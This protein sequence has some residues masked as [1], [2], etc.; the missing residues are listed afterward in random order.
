MIKFLLGMITAFVIQ[1]WGVVWP[2]LE[3]FTIYIGGL[4]K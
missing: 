1:N 3:K 2:I 4:L